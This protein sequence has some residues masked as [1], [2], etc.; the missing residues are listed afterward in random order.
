MKEILVLTY[1]GIDAMDGRGLLY[2]QP[3]RPIRVRGCILF[4]TSDIPATTPFTGCSLRGYRHACKNCHIQ[5][6]MM[7]INQQDYKHAQEQEKQKKERKKQTKKRKKEEEKEEE[8][9]EEKEEEKIEVEEENEE[10]DEEKEEKTKKVD[11]IFFPGHLLYLPSDKKSK[12]LQKTARM[13]M[14]EAFTRYVGDDENDRV[15]LAP[16]SKSGSELLELGDQFALC[17]DDGERKRLF[18]ETGCRGR[19]ALHEV[20]EVFN[21]VNNTVHDFMHLLYNVIL[22]VFSYMI[23]DHFK[24][25]RKLNFFRE[26]RKMEVN[27]DLKEND[28]DLKDDHD[29]KTHRSKAYML[30]QASNQR[31]RELMNSTRLRRVPIGDDP[32]NLDCPFDF[33]NSGS[34][35]LTIDNSAAWVHMI[36]PIG[37]YYIHALDIHIE[38]KRAFCSLLWELYF[39]RRRFVLLDQLNVS[40]TGGEA[41]VTSAVMLLRALAKLESL[42]PIHFNTIVIHLLQH[43][44]HTLRFTG[45][46]HATW[47][48]V[49]ERWVQIA[50]KAINSANSAMVTL[51]NAITERE[52]T[53]FGRY[54]TINDLNDLITPP[55]SHSEK[56]QVKMIGAGRRV[57]LDQR[58]WRCIYNFLLDEDPVYS[59][60]SDEY[61]E[62]NPTW[63]KKGRKV[64]EWVES[65]PETCKKRM[66]EKIEEVLKVSISE[67]QLVELMKGPS[68]EVMRYN[69]FESNGTTFVTDGWEKEKGRL[70]RKHC[71]YLNQKQIDEIKAGNRPNIPIARIH[72]IYQIKIASNIPTLRKTYQL[73]AINNFKYLDAHATQLP[74]VSPLSR[75]ATEQTQP[76]IQCGAV[77]PYNIALWPA[78][79]VKDNKRYVAVW[80]DAH[81]YQM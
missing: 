42:M 75:I 22:L 27:G 70:A 47:M 30:W 62:R 34:P 74:H 63:Q 51:F 68:V 36:G 19:P 61:K 28:R 8:E 20:S 7:I 50:K 23:R 56:T 12:E 64:E 9:I 32:S 48:F 66:R 14:G 78:N 65:V 58:R 73:L 69:R 31:L 54:Q 45:P 6:K 21:V 72:H 44:H 33:D 5:G 55:P 41:N 16:Q 13:C 57:K 79:Y 15:P 76:I 80:I 43:A 67:E 35:K 25:A 49:F 37:V 17:C 2:G 52:W 39:M 26:K 3:L 71:F 60:I 18:D 24:D 29:K 11:T 77:R 53:T 81:H 4:T 46:V 38:Y 1:R 40:F 59:I 10:E